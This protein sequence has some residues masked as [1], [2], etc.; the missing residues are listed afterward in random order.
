VS[1][2][3]AQVYELVAQIPA[4]K[5]ATYGQL[6]ALLGHPRAARTVG[7]AMQATP[8]DMRIPAHRVINRSGVMAP[9]YVFGGA[10]A[11]R[12]ALEAEGVTFT[13]DGRVHVAR[14]LWAGPD[15]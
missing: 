12:A 5:V 1:Q 7:W 13:L 4:G 14:H 2:F 8:H 10:E 9:A 11:Q 3:F 6:A 15:S